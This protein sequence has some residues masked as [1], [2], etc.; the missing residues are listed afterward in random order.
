[1]QPATSLSDPRNRKEYTTQATAMTKAFEACQK[2]DR[3]GLFAHM[4]SLSVAKDMEAVR[5]ALGEERL[6]FMA[7]SYGGV[8]AGAYARLFPHR[9]R[10]MYLDGVINQ[11]LGWPDQQLRTYPARERGFTTFTTWCAATPACALHGQDAAA[12]WRKLTQDADRHPIPVTSSQFGKGKLTGW[13][14][15]AIGFMND[16]GPDNSGWLAFAEAVAKAR[17]GDGSGFADFVLGN[18]RTWALPGVMAMSCGDERGYTGYAQL[19]KA[20]RQSMKISPN[21]GGGAGM[22]ALACAGWPLKVANPSRPLPARGLP[23]VLGIG[24]TW[25]D[26]A[27]TES[28]TEMIPGSVAV[29]YE[30]PG[31]ALYLTKKKCPIRHAT[32]YLTD[33]TL[34]KPGTTCPAE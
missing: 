9:I 8:A 6:S 11:V 25:G 34:P 14:L 3:T 18:T 2:A 32:A 13:H 23:P 27:W 7:N 26:Y 4:D 16:P 29:A 24:S 33:L 1:M 21:F 31:H 5:Q 30:G 12:E 19:R 22:D 10:A 28:F 15:R 20:R 17:R